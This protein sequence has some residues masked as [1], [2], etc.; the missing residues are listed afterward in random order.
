M[1]LYRA[2]TLP[3][4]GTCYIASLKVNGAEDGIQLRGTIMKGEERRKY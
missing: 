3:E 4:W 1:H 2:P